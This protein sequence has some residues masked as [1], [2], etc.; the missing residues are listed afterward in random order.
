MPVRHIKFVRRMFVGEQTYEAGDV[1]QFEDRKAAKIVE[2]GHA[3]YVLAV[4]SDPDAELQKATAPKPH[5]ERATK[6]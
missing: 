5:A 3:V 2:L 6:K 4:A 1:D